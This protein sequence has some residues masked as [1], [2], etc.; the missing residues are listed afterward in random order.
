MEVGVG[1]G[2]SDFL[3]D[4]GHQPVM[5]KDSHI[6]YLLPW[7]QHPFVKRDINLDWCF[8]PVSTTWFIFPTIPTTWA[9]VV[10]STQVGIN[11]LPIIACN[12][13]WMKVWVF[14]YLEEVLEAQL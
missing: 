3:P 11:S 1:R 8:D 6:E 2:L 5:V 7:V 10:L 13:L 4:H 12:V 14:N 9:L